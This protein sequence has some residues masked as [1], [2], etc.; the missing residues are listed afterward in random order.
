MRMLYEKR[1]APD[2][3]VPPDFLKRLQKNGLFSFY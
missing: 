3:W 1:T 2:N